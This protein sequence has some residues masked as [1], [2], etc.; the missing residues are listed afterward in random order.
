MVT[1]EQNLQIIGLIYPLQV[2][3]KYS[4]FKITKKWDKNTQGECFAA[5]VR[6]HIEFLYT[7]RGYDTGYYSA[8]PK[9]IPSDTKG[10]RIVS[11][12]RD[13]QSHCSRNEYTLFNGRVVYSVSDNWGRKRVVFLK[14]FEDE[15][16]VATSKENLLEIIRKIENREWFS[17][18]FR[19]AHRQIKSIAKAR[20][21][22]Q[23]AK[24]EFNWA[25]EILHNIELYTSLPIPKEV[26]L[27][28]A[29]KQSHREFNKLSKKWNID[30][31][32]A[33][34]PRK[35]TYCEVIAKMISQMRTPTIKINDP[36]IVSYEV[37]QNG[38]YK[39]CNNLS[40]QKHVEQEGWEKIL[41]KSLGG[42]CVVF[43]NPQNPMTNDLEKIL[44]INKGV[45]ESSIELSWQMLNAKIPKIMEFISM[46]VKKQ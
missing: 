8:K 32:G 30:F 12:S 4:D 36:Y 5:G 6:W 27:T 14:K 46:K 24:K 13:M 15:L 1:L 10:V 26:W 40:I 25:W 20:V 38:E 35:Q 39:M 43:I 44:K 19:N 21:F 17:M 28:L 9:S 31:D 2:L 11:E 22:V 29:T 16:K 37:S 18:K 41:M 23:I 42:Q 34:L 3:R 7:D 45:G 33:S